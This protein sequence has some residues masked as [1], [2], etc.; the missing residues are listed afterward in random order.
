MFQLTDGE[1]LIQDNSIR[2]PVDWYCRS[3]QGILVYYLQETERIRKNDNYCFK[4]QVRVYPTI[5][6]IKERTV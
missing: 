1:Y 2:P 4:D 6:L 3:E 5:L